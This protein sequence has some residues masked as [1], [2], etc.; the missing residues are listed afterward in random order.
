M[1]YFEQK[2]G[3]IFTLIELLVV[4]AIIGILASLLLPALKQ[5]RDSAK[6]ISCVNNHK[7][8]GLAMMSYANDNDNWYPDHRKD[9][10]YSYFQREGNLDHLFPAYCSPEA[11]ACPSL[12]HHPTYRHLSMV[13]IAGDS[14]CFAPDTDPNNGYQV[15]SARRV[16]F[17]ENKVKKMDF[18]QDGPS[19]RVLAADFFYGWDGALNYTWITNT[20]SGGKA[21]DYPSLVAHK[22]KNS[23]TVYEDG[24]VETGNNPI[25][26]Q[27][28][29]WTE[30][31]SGMGCWEH[32]GPYWGYHWAQYPTVYVGK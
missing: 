15:I 30:W 5:A 12:P 27:W 16:G 14:Y 4:I 11:A 1:R 10:F 2:R 29:N 22:G 19:R 13:I 7:Q 18:C 8:V 28:F 6:L 23:N 31:T 3:H 24:H 20:A 21:G 17:Y 32:G 25:H 26:R 9:L